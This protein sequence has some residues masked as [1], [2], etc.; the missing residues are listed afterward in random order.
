MNASSPGLRPLTVTLLD[1]L[2]RFKL[3]LECS[4]A[5]GMEKVIQLCTESWGS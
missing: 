5:D 4:C 1:D 3:L 2:V